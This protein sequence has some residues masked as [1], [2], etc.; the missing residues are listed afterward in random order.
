MKTAC[1]VFVL[2]ACVATVYAPPFAAASR[3]QAQLGP[4]QSSSGAA[5]APGA[6]HVRPAQSNGEKDQTDQAAADQPGEASNASGENGRR[7]Q[8][9]SP[10][11]PLHKLSRSSPEWPVSGA[12][13]HAYRRN[14]GSGASGGAAKDARMQNELIVRPA[15]PSISRVRHR[16]PNPPIIGGLGNTNAKSTGAINGTRINRKP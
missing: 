4:S 15:V 9:T 16:S 3:P 14:A 11:K 8:A 7:I 10:N 5:A 12:A 1:P 2:I 13:L 6:D